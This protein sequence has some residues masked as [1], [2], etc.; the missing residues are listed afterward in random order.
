VSELEQSITPAREGLPRGYKMR[1]S[2]HYVDFLESKHQ[3]AVIRLIP[4]EQIHVTDLPAAGA[5]TALTESV[6]KHG[7]LQPLF[8]RPAAGGRYQLIAG[9]RRL[10]A[11]LSVGVTE[12]PCIVHH[13]DDDGVEALAGADNVRSEKAAA[14][15]APS[16]EVHELLV[17]ISAGLAGVRSLAALLASGTNIFHSR[18]AA[19][20][21][22]AQTARAQ[23]LASAA[24]LMSSSGQPGRTGRLGAIV[25]RA[26][27]SLEPEARISNLALDVKIGP[28]AAMIE[29]DEHVG[30]AISGLI[31]ATLSWLD[32]CDDKRIEVRADEPHHGTVNLQVVQ[33]LSA[34]PVEAALYFQPGGVFHP[35]AIA[36]IG[37]KT[38][39]I[40]A[41]QN[42]GT[43]QFSAIG[44]Y[45]SVVQGVFCCKS[46][47][48]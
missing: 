23:W 32:G 43:L 46:S 36:A 4:T 45:G 31:L 21:L 37:I 8:V 6:M 27:S 12:V 13:V 29:V 22:L 34:P 18:Q 19:D 14:A 39:Q 33:R 42:G 28:S 47:D 1:A 38:A 44:R 24:G 25:Q 11:A 26:T 48:N 16:R 41:A 20:L 7:V 10:A 5:V 40:V 2:A 3:A 9:R 35:H 17:A 30:T 15:P